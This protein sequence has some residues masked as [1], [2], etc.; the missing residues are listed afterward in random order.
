MLAGSIVS[1]GV[2]PGLAVWL[3]GSSRRDAV[4]ARSALM[5]RFAALVASA[6]D[7]R[8]NGIAGR[9]REE[10]TALDTKASALER[11]SAWSLGLGSGIVTLASG[12]TSL[13]MLAVGAPAVANGE[14]S[15]GLMAVLVLTPRAMVEVYDDVVEAVQ[16]WPALRTVVGR[17]APLLDDAPLTRSGDMPD[18]L[19]QTVQD[20]TLD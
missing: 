8:V 14:I 1:L 12:V 15:H 17:F 2:A 3:D 20:L 6:A 18:V 9:A 16:P 4:L 5:R 19:P 11:R 7:L 13:A 10:I